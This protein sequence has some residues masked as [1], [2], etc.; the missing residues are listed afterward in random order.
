MQEYA[1]LAELMTQKQIYT[2]PSVTFKDLCRRVRTRPRRMN[3]LLRTELGM[4]G[5]ALLQALRDGSLA[6]LARN[7]GPL[8]K[9]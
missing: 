9:K 8:D 3:Q 2:D 5:T 4:D 1:A 6:A 7:Y